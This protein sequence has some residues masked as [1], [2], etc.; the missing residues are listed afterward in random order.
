MLDDLVAGAAADTAPDAPATDP[1]ARAA[2]VQAF[3]TGS[4]M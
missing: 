4:G 3:I 1:A 2:Q